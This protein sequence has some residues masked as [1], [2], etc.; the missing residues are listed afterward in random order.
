MLRKYTLKKET[1]KSLEENL[2]LFYTGVQR[3]AREILSTQKNNIEKADKTTT[4]VQMTQ[5][6]D[7]LK[8]A[9]TSE[10]L[11][12]FGACFMKIGN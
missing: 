12:V 3:K 11:S 2:I 8:K 7:E 1:V 10:Q 5:L 6:V 9:L 4:L